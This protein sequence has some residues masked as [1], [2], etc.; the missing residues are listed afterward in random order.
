ML[1]TS[2][3]TGAT[4]KEL[5]ARLGHA[6]PQAAMIYQH[7]ASDRDRSIAEGLTAMLR[8][9]ESDESGQSL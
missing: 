7:A 1:I 3:R 6:S 2:T 5:M 9:A 4:T 8:I